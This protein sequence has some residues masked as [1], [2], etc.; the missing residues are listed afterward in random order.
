ML[1]TLF[2]A[3]APGFTNGRPENLYETTPQAREYTEVEHLKAHSVAY[4]SKQ[5]TIDTAMQ[6][7]VDKA[8]EKGA[9]GVVDAKVDAGC[10][11]FIVIGIPNCHAKAEG[12][13]VDWGKEPAPTQ[14]AQADAAEGEPQQP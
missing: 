10:N 3:C 7:L 11:I 14:P 2:L 5:R 12:V 4:A 1:L 13:A 9:D 6:K 8:E